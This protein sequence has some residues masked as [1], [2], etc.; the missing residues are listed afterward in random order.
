MPLSLPKCE[1]LVRISSSIKVKI[2][3]W[4]ARRKPVMQFSCS[5]APSPAA[6]TTSLRYCT[7]A[8]VWI[9]SKDDLRQPLCGS[10]E[11]TCSRRPHPALLLSQPKIPSWRE[12]TLAQSRHAYFAAGGLLASRCGAPPPP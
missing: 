2:I 8:R 12:G 6:L 7:F 10:K 9:C 11:G 5:S 4:P 3:I 1:T